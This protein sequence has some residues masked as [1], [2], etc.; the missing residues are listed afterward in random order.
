MKKQRFSKTII[1]LIAIT[2]FLFFNINQA[3]AQCN[4]IW[5]G[6]ESGYAPTLEDLSM[7]QAT[8]KA[9]FAIFG[10]HPFVSGPGEEWDEISSEWYCGDWHN[11][12][13]FNPNVYRIHSTFEEGAPTDGWDVVCTDLCESSGGDSDID[14]I[15]D[16]VD[17]CIITL[18]HLQEDIDNDGDGDVCDDDI[19]GDNIPNATDNCP[20]TWNAAQN[21]I[22]GD[23]IGTWCDNCLTQ[24]NPNQADSD[25]DGIGNWCDNCPSNCN[26]QQLDADDDGVGD[27]C[28]ETPGCGGC[29]Q[30]D[31]ET[32]CSE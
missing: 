19:D 24:W 1:F 2:F 32:T 18:N 15:C 16:N 13:E 12:V 10:R 9:F 21:D 5:W 26:S 8:C 27:V 25:G 29:G 3:K 7:E 30:D 4:I 17:N 6:E 22:D 14:G 28:D 23:G 31:C 11:G 20:D